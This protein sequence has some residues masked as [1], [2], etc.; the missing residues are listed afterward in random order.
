MAVLGGLY[1]HPRGCVVY[2]SFGYV[3]NAVFLL[4]K[5]L[6]TDNELSGQTIYLTDLELME[7]KD[8]ANTIRR[9][10]GTSPVREVPLFFLKGLAKIGDF[11]TFVGWRRAPLTSFRLSNL[12][13]DMDFDTSELARLVGSTELPY[14]SEGGVKETLRWLGEFKKKQDKDMIE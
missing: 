4:D 2:K 5:L 8:W 3:G 1:I 10:A 6:A 11:M 9:E 7:V 12:I 14:G 13:T